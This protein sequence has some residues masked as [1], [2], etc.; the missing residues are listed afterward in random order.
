MRIGDCQQPHGI[1]FSGDHT[2]DALAAAVLRFVNLGGHS[3]DKA[4][5]AEND[6]HFRMGNQVFLA[7]F[8]DTFLINFGT[9]LIAEFFFQFIGSCLIKA[10]T[11]LALPSK[12]SR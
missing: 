4:A 9:A 12:S 5:V 1:F 3:L 7:E 6:G 8:L 2:D 11:R 10:R